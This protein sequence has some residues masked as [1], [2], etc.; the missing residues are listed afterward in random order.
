MHT[1]REMYFN[2]PFNAKWMQLK[3][4]Q[5]NTSHPVEWCHLR[6]AV[7]EMWSSVLSYANL[8]GWHHVPQKSSHRFY[9]T[10]CTDF[11]KLIINQ[12][13]LNYFVQN[14]II[15]QIMNPSILPCTTAVRADNH[16]RQP[17]YDAGPMISEDYQYPPY[18]SSPTHR[19]CITICSKTQ[20]WKC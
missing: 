16:S 8:R 6:A 9:R 3:G 19:I 15:P 18:A 14:F 17:Q 1:D 11:L 7:H 2:R 10:P 13:I 20:P 12:H 4:L 5:H